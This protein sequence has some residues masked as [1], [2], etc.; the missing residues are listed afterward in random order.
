MAFSSNEIKKLKSQA[1]SLKG[2]MNELE[3]DIAKTEN[4]FNM[5]NLERLDNLKTKLELSKKFLEQSDSFSK[6]TAELEDLLESERKD[7]SLACAKL[8]A[9]QKS[10]EGQKGLAGDNE[11][12]LKLEEFKNRIEASITKNVV[13]VLTD[14]N[15]EES[16]KYV[17]MFH[18]IDRLAQLKSYYGTI[19]QESYRRNWIEICGSIENSENPR[20]LSDFYDI[21]LN[22]WNKQLKWY[23]EVFSCDGVVEIVNVIADTLLTLNPTRES[24]ISNYLKRINE[25]MELLSEVSHSNVKF[26]NDI[27]EKIRDSGITLSADKA[28]ALSYS[29]FN[30]F[31]IFIVTYSTLE[32]S[33]L[34]NKFD[35]LKIIQ[36]NGS[37]TVRCLE[38]S[39]SKVF[40]WINEAI[41]RQ[42]SITQ[43]CAIVSFI[44]ILNTFFRSKLLEK[45]KKAQLQI[46]ASRTE[47]QDWNLFQI[48]IALLQNIG[49]FKIKL[50]EVEEKIKNLFL[51]KSKQMNNSE[52]FC[53]KIVNQRDVSDFSKILTRL[54]SNE[55]DLIIFESV[56]PILDTVLKE[57]NYMMLRNVFTPIETY[58]K[59]IEINNASSSADLPDFS[60]TP[61]T[62]VTE[63]GQFL[64]TLPERIEPFL[65]N[66]EKSLKIALELSDSS[67]KENDVPCAD[68]LL[69]IISDET[70]SLYISK[71]RQIDSIN[72]G[73]AKQLSTDIEYLGSVLEELG[74]TLVSQLKHIAQL[75]KVKQQNYLSL[76]IGADHK[77]IA[78][79]RQ[80]RNINISDESN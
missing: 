80:M 36:T 4:A 5:A 79:I 59:G 56:K 32:Q 20:F 21:F 11:R 45:F 70:C 27:L 67:Y 75:L 28:S 24:V 49:S 1:I 54:N 7:I 17:D 14:G 39:I 42:S 66:P 18:K 22:S 8:H 64:L 25:K 55:P 58:F 10:Y 76:N 34:D 6:L 72:D 15:I 73:E 62:Y 63:I 35:N 19:Q 33:N 74:I 9:L 68:I 48:C 50:D 69:R 44:Y 13:K 61:L 78:A 12:E 51:K 37:E 77:L 38:N 57:T 60:L 52:E 71:I 46:S 65:L 40:E 3:K 41:D 2:K 26:S 30:Y 47:I 53:Y 29:I 43:D 23:R 31:N 16:L